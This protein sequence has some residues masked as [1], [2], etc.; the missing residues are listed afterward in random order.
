MGNPELAIQGMIPRG[1]KAFALTEQ[2]SP[3]RLHNL[4]DSLRAAWGHTFA[5]VGYKGVR[6]VMK[7]LR[8]GGVVALMGD[9]DIH[10]P[11]ALLP[12]FG[13][14]AWM[15]TGP[16][17]VALRTNAVVIPAFCIRTEDDGIVAYLEEPLE[18]QRSGDTEADVRENTLRYLARLEAYLKRYP[19]QWAVLESIWD[20]KTS[21]PAATPLPVGEQA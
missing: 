4:V 11:K 14:E 18:L 10:G 3:P 15:P 16:M 17:E 20:G 9:R 1:V 19:D 2:L 21:E 6:E 8:N 7:R 12:F 5:P 13:E